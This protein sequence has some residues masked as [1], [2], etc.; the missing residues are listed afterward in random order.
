VY[1][2]TARFPVIGHQSIAL[3]IESRRDARLVMHGRLN[4]DE[5]VQYD[6]DENG[7]FSFELT[8]PTLKIL[9]RFRTKLGK[10]GYDGDVDNAWVDVW[11][12]VPLSIRIQLKRVQ[13]PMLAHSFARIQ[14]PRKWVP[15]FVK[16]RFTFGQSDE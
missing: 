4:L 5:P 3:A 16:R 6:L 2:H 13:R 8:E 12:P 15:D 1:S 10:V 7:D 9:R 11:P 14:K